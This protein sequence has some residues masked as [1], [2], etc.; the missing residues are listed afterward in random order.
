MN[1]IKQTFDA[2]KRE[3]RK[4]LITFI[5]AGDPTIETTK[6]LVIE[7]EKRGANIIELGIPYSDPI[8]E[9]P[10]IQ[11]AN[12]RALKNNL[13]LK[14]IMAAAA[15]IRK[16]VSVPLIYLLYFNSI[17]QYGIEKFLRD[18]VNSGVDGLIIPDLPYEEKNEIAD[19]ASKYNID[20]I[21]MVS[22]TSK[23]RIEK[24]A[25]DAKGFLYCVSSLGVTGVRNNFDTDFAEFFGHID[26][27][28][29]VPKAVGFGISTGEQIRNLRRFCDG[30]II[31]SAIVK[32]VE[33]SSCE[34]DAV[35]KVGEY[36][37]AMRN[38]LDN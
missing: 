34:E 21:S 16:E 19:S 14:D 38:A 31:G 2:L 27:Y 23:D 30:I 28:A 15:E 12:S 7:M 8:A 9:G 22:P 32:K 24:I 29:N 3:N 18:C 17:L 37:Q 6:K 35:E 4:A 25:K 11:A 5:T 26:R 13:R 36:V 10:V 20:I 33:E 1:R